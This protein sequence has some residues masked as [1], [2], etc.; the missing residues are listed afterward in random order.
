VSSL[1][2]AV[3]GMHCAHCLRTVEQ[4]L[5][6][7]PGVAAARAN[8]STKRVRVETEAE[9]AT[10]VAALKSLGF[11]ANIARAEPNQSDELKGLIRALAVAAFGSMNIMLLAVA[12]WAGLA[13]DM[14]AATRTLFYWLQ[15]LICIPTVAYAGMPFFRSAAQAL[16]H[17][18]LNMDVPISLAVIITPLVSVLEV[19]REEPHAYF[20]G[21]VMLLLFLLVGRVLDRK[22]RAQAWSV[23]ENLLALQAVSAEVVDADGG[24][25]TVTPDQLRPGM[26]VAVA[27][28]ARIPADGVVVD[29]RSDLDLSLVTGETLPEAVLPGGQVFAG[30]LNLT[31]P[32][33]VQ[34]SKAA[35][36]SLVAELVRLMES[37]EQNRSRY[38]RV[39]DRLAAAYAPAVHIL[40][41]AT[42]IGWLIWGPDWHAALM[43][44]V[45]VLIITCPC[46]LGLAMPVVQVAA[47]G[48][49]R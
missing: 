19:I 2:F 49:R 37:A 25:R 36:Q 1:E 21:A 20:D 38:V 9:P 17:K 27:M 7:V 44:A 24:R 26:Q 41:A 3:P 10:V 34:V 48:W 22:V 30:T 42:F 43:A 47:N 18:R 8:L 46:A 35:D 11:D 6:K 4:G 12:V 45:A 39:A 31:G 14:E 5:V 32:L 33:L 23:A 16:R 29:G 40:S 15:A 28:G 13:S